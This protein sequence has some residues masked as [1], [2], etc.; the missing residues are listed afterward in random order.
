MEAQGFSAI[1]GA[2]TDLLV[3]D[4]GVYITKIR[5]FGSTITGVVFVEIEGTQSIKTTFN[6]AF[7]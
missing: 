5:D 1:G 6:D 4:D 2:A 3:A 7:T